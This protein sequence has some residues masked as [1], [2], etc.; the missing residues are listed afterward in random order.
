MDICK[1]KA[2]LITVIPGHP[3]YIETLS[4]KEGD[5]ERSGIRGRGREHFSCKLEALLSPLSDIWNYSVYTKKL[6]ISAL[7]L[8]LC[9]ES[10]SKEYTRHTGDLKCQGF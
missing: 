8:A 6:L 4:Q 9:P 10:G 1:F 5:F 3:G 7:I 2:S